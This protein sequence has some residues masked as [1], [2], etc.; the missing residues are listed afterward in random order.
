[1]ESFQLLKSEEKM[2]REE[3]LLFDQ[4]VQDVKEWWASPRYKG[5]KRPYS[6]EDVVGK[7]GSFQQV[8]SSSLMA[9]KLFDLLKAKA[10]MG[11]PVHTRASTQ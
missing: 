5:I 9:Q 4:Q 1:M 7:R 2:G 8:Y 3:D 10:T 6:P 11:E